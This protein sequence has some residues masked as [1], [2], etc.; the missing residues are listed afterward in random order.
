MSS[1]PYQAPSADLNEVPLQTGTELATRGE[2]FA[3]A[4]IDTILQLIILLPL[5]F[6]A[7]TF[8]VP[9]SGIVSALEQAKWAALG[10]VVYV[11]L[12]G[13]FL[14]TDG[15]TIGKKAMSVGIVDMH[16]DI[17]PL[18]RILLL[19]Q[20]PVVVA[21]MIGNVLPIV[22]ALFIFRSDRRCLHDLIAGT[23]VIRVPR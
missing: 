14:H 3:A 22:D 21:S 9:D 19:R 13:Y 4:I 8:N 12:N 1:N 17:P 20:L 10:L 16:G 2:R 6:L 11:L 15:Q 23:K 18:H 7:G 5:M